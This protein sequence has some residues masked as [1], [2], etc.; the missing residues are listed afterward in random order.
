VARLNFA[1]FC[2]SIK[3]NFKGIKNKHKNVRRGFNEKTGTPVRLSLR[4]VAPVAPFM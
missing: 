3:N 4:T 1:Q 2:F